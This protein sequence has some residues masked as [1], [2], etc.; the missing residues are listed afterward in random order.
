MG[1]HIPSPPEK[2][3]IDHI[4]VMATPDEVVA[5]TTALERAGLRMADAVVEP[6]LGLRSRMFPLGG[7]GFIEVACEL[8]PGSFPHG[9]PF[10]NTPRIANV[11]YTTA[12]GAADMAAWAKKPGTADAMAQCGSWRREDGSMGYFVALWPI[13]PTGELFFALQE[14]RLFPLPFLEEAD[15]APEVCAVRVYGEEAGL[16]QQRHRDLFELEEDGELLRAGNAKLAFDQIDG[17]NT[18][19]E[20][21]LAVPNPDV[22]IPLASG[23]FTLVHQVHRVPPTD[24]GPT[25]SIRPPHPERQN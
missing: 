11:S 18:Q 22:E 3:I 16:W 19:I 7:G 15:T 5:I 14:R 8:T 24:S 2:R 12:D 6:A 25:R 4:I 9:N 1:A 10:E 13:P 17:L 21:T 23:A 20:V